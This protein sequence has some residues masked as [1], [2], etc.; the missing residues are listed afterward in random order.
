MSNL[1]IIYYIDNQTQT[2]QP[3]IKERDGNTDDWEFIQYFRTRINGF[4]YSE[5]EKKE[6]KV[7]ISTSYYIDLLRKGYEYK[8]IITL[9]R[10]EFWKQY[11]LPR[12]QNSF[13]CESSLDYIVMELEAANQAYQEYSKDSNCYGLSD[14]V[15]YAP[16]WLENSN[17]PNTTRERTLKKISQN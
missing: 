11:E 14:Y 3:F 15:K 1:E 5:K 12:S 16:F 10:Q 7:A 4:N 9:L 17:I 13:N 8:E 6:T 2:I